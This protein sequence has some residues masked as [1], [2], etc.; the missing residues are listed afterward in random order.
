MR[1]LFCATNGLSNDA[2]AFLHRLTHRPY[3]TDFSNSFVPNIS[4]NLL[5]Q[6]IKNLDTSG[7]YIFKDTVSNELCDRLTKFTRETEAEFVDHNE[8]TVRTK[9][10]FNPQ[11]PRGIRYNFPMRDIMS[12]TAAQE[13]A[14]DPGLSA[15]AQA[16][17]RAK[18]VQD[19]VAMWW[20]CPG[21]SASSAAAQMYHFD[22]PRIK[23]LKFFIYLTDVDETNGPHCYVAGSHRRLPKPLR[24]DRR[25]TEK[26]VQSHYAPE[27]IL[28]IKGPKGT[29]CAIDTRGLHK[30]K[31]LT[32]GNRL[33]FQTEFAINLFGA[34]YPT[35]DVGDNFSASSIERIKE[36]PYTY[37]NYT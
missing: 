35:I 9:T 25:F 34:S 29:L 5:R 1:K 2:F 30:G 13:I 17:F 20:S 14:T 11:D 3:K 32:K 26:E 37:A 19:M 18:A 24:Q 10:V 23:F 33:I 21:D 27:K 8:T 12:C 6:I 22:M 4:D 7:Y 36:E 15:I 16:Y 31:Q 28:E